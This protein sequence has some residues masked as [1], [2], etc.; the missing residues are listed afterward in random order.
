[1]PLR[2]PVLPAGASSPVLEVSCFSSGGS[3]AW[4]ALHA[5]KSRTKPPRHADSTDTT[6]EATKTLIVL[7]LPH[8]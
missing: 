7:K 2:F 8:P 1:M 5:L 6:N 3:R 4:A